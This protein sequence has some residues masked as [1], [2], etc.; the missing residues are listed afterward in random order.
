M[1]TW[2]IKLKT[3]PAKG[4]SL[5]KQRGGVQEDDKNGQILGEL[6]NYLRENKFMST[7]MLCRQIEK[8]EIVGNVAKHFAKEGYHNEIESNAAKRKEINEFFESRGLSFVVE[9][10]KVE[11]KNESE[12][13]ELF[14]NKLKVK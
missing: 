14:G 4:S 11:E 5:S 3:F 10:P 7:L 8:I 6:L 12:L 13:S 2:K 1:K 9:Q